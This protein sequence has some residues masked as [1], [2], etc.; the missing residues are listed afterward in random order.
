MPYLLNF[1]T[2]RPDTRR[3]RFGRYSHH[4]NNTLNQSQPRVEIPQS[5]NLH[6][7]MWSRGMQGW[8]WKRTRCLSFQD[9][10]QFQISISYKAYQLKYLHPYSLSTHAPL[11]LSFNLVCRRV[12]KALCKYLRLS[13]FGIISI[14][15]TIPSFRLP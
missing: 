1:P 6:F 14:D 3:Q 5:P 15:T 2:S 10:V 11:V 8:Q 7:A 12:S 9:H 13:T 4:T